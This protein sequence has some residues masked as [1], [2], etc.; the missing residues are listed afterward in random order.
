[1]AEKD[2]RDFCSA[3]HKR[4]E[5]HRKSM[6]FRAHPGMEGWAPKKS[7]SQN[8][9]SPGSRRCSL[10]VSI[11]SCP[12][13]DAMQRPPSTPR[14]PGPWTPSTPGRDSP[15]DGP[16]EHIELEPAMYPMGRRTSAFRR[17]VR[18]S[19]TSVSEGVTPPDS[20]QELSRITTEVALL[21]RKPLLATSPPCHLHFFAH[22][23]EKN[24]SCPPLLLED[25]EPTGAPGR[26]KEPKC[27]S[28]TS[29]TSFH[30]F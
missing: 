29:K 15:H 9:P 24:G 2:P 28:T 3:A 21:P 13:C 10:L 14:N 5:W 22:S 1:M 19:R 4:A 27:T 26:R 16:P 17:E 11:S 25:L 20:H 8:R 23:A 6:P 7:P 30:R 12:P 18:M